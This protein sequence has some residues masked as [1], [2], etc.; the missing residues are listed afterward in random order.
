[1]NGIAAWL[2]AAGFA[3]CLVGLGRTLCLL[4]GLRELEWTGRT[5]RLVAWWIV[6]GHAAAMALLALALSTGMGPGA[7]G[8]AGAVCLPLAGYGAWRAVREARA[9]GAGPAA[10]RNRG[11]TL[12]AA[13]LGLLW[14]AP[15]AVQ[16][17]MPDLDWDS[18]AYHR[19]LARAL[20]AGENAAADPLLA[21]RCFPAGMHLFYAALIALGSERALAPF[22]LIGTLLGAAAVYA[23]G[24]RFWG[25]AAGG[26]G[27]L[28]LLSSNIVV[29]LGLDARVDHFLGLYFQAALFFLLLWREQGR[30]G[31]LVLAGMALGAGIGVKYTGLLILPA[32]LLGL[33]GSGAA[34][35]APLALAAALAC[36]AVPHGYWYGRNAALFGDPLYPFLGGI[37]FRSAAGSLEPL[38]PAVER[39]AAAKPRP[40]EDFLPVAPVGRKERTMYD[41]T[42]ALLDSSKYTDKAYHWL[43]PLALL[44]FLLPLA[45]RSRPA[46]LLY[47]M[48][49]VAFAGSGWVY[50]LL[51]YVVHILPPLSLAGALFVLRTPWRPLKAL[52]CLAL[53]GLLAHNGWWE[54]H[55]LAAREPMACLAG[56]ETEEEFIRRRGYNTSPA[57]PKLAAFVGQ[58]LREGTLRPG[59]RILM[60]GED[61]GE[62]LACA[63]IPDTSFFG[64]RWLAELADQGGDLD[65]LRAALRGRGVTHLAANLG[66]FHWVLKTLPESVP[67]LLDHRALRLAL[68]HFDRFLARHGELIYAD[69]GIFLVKIL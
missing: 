28:A 12:A 39:L 23:T 4:P 18:A 57:A 20:A 42:G 9:A 45:C 43:S 59:A 63:Y 13:G 14:F 11:V 67:P 65:R 52:Y 15:L 6:G 22:N 53:A 49:L 3:A 54:W 61:K 48:T 38:A 27:A 40:P 35:R 19:P 47:A 32:A 21:Q 7:L 36:I 50:S 41:L 64:A 33:A 66:Y 60:I 2:A 26:L 55:K 69:G 37:V 68:F 25:R 5:E 8:A 10:R 56:R 31:L 30:G 24:R 16:A 51:R 34:R 58:A 62:A 46:G 1:M 29:E 17:A 44:G